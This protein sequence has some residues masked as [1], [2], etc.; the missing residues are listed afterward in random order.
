MMHYKMMEG[1]N[2]KKVIMVLVSMAV[3]VMLAHP[4]VSFAE[5]G[6]RD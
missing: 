4:S 5:I 6:V 3:I 1:V 2:M